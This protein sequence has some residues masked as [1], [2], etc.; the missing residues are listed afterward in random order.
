MNG[1]RFIVTTSHDLAII[2]PVFRDPN[3]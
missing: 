1:Q 3:D 2:H